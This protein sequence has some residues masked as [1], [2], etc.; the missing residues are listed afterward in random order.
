MRAN[1]LAMPTPT[2]LP[3]VTP[4]AQLMSTS[5]SR[6]AGEPTTLDVPPQAQHP[7]GEG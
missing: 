2:L 5:P 3:A 6:R 4:K 1:V 7:R